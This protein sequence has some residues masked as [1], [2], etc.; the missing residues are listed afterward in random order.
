MVCGKRWGEWLISLRKSM[1]PFVRTIVGVG[2][3]V[4]GVVICIAFFSFF[5]HLS[6]RFPTTNFFDFFISAYSCQ[7]TMLSSK[8]ASF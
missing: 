4:V 6:F 7:F 3:V 8:F 2:V 5:H 1:I